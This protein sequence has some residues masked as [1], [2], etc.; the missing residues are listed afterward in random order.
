MAEYLVYFEQMAK[1][2][3]WSLREVAMWDIARTELVSLTPEQRCDLCQLTG[4]LLQSFCPTKLV[5][6]WYISIKWS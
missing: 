1:F 4:S 3:Q 2:Q 6:S 5:L